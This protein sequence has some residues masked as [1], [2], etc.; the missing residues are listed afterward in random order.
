MLWRSGDQCSFSSGLFRSGPSGSTILFVVIYI[1]SKCI[2]RIDV[3]SSWPTSHIGSPTCAVRTVMMENAKWK[4]LVQSPTRKIV[5]KS[6][7]VFLEELQRLVTPERT[8]KFAGVVSGLYR[9]QMDLG[10]LEWIVI[11]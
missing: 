1:V 11:D 4:S 2:L 9:R 8:L 5:N 3:L 10:E 6:N 7:T